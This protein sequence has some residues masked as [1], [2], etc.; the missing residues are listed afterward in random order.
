M[1]KFGRI[2]SALAMTGAMLLLAG[3]PKAEEE[4]VE[5]VKPEVGPDSRMKDPE[6]VKQLDRLDH[7]RRVMLRDMEATRAK[8]EAAK[9]QDPEGAETKRLEA[10]MKE[11]P[12]RYKQF[13][14]RAR[15]AVAM[16]MHREREAM[17]QY[18]ADKAEYDRR[19]A[20]KEG[21]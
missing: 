3:C 4:L 19:K 21:K 7:D 10:E 18:E 2:F 17:K 12:N 16:R 1:S 15:G 11:F 14:E 6:Y 8:Y 5:P 9:A 13:E 20:A